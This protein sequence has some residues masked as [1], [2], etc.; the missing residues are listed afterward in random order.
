MDA[1]PTPTMTFTVQKQS[2][3]VGKLVADFSTTVD[4]AAKCMVDSMGKS[5]TTTTTVSGGSTDKDGANLYASLPIY[6]YPH[7]HLY[8]Y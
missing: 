2:S 4:V 5:S 3:I 8:S 6:Y 7:P 1:D